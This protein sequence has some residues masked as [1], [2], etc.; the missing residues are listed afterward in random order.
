[1]IPG[2]D[3]ALIKNLLVWIEAVPEEK[4]SRA[5]HARQF[6]VEGADDAERA[7][8]ETL[9]AEIGTEAKSPTPAV[10][11]SAETKRDRRLYSP[12]RRGYMRSTIEEGVRAEIDATNAEARGSP[13][14]DQSVQAAS[15]PSNMLE[16]SLGER[17]AKLKE[18]AKK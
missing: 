10:V 2:A 4:E 14:F 3:K 7:R 8:I 15:V 5:E 13:F 18:K 6:L 16:R 12:E 17:L 11:T 9:L 1:M